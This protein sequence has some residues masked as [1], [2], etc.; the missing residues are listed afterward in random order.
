VKPFAETAFGGRL[1]VAKLPFYYRWMMQ[2]AKTP[3]GDY[4]NW[5]EIQAWAA[6]L[7]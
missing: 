1:E 3:D 5:P 7:L 6:S 4:R 2:M